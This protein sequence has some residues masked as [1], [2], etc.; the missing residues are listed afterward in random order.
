MNLFI[1]FHHDITVIMVVH[2]I[3]NFQIMSGDLYLYLYFTIV[4]DVCCVPFS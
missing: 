2:R 1:V 4:A 3:L